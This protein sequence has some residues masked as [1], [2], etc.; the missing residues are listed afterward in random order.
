LIKQKH[1][2][3]EEEEEK[4]VFEEEDSKGTDPKEETFDEVKTTKSGRVSRPV[5]KYVTMHHA[6]LQTQAIDPQEY[7][8]DTAKVIVQMINMMNMQLLRHTV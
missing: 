8:I 3:E 1:L 2:I 5:H 4:I 7:N 6:H